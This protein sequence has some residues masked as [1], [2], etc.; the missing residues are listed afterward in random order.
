VTYFL[1][2]FYEYMWNHESSDKL[3]L[4]ITDAVPFDGSRTEMAYIKLGAEQ[5]ALDLADQ[6]PYSCRVRAC[7]VCRVCR[8]CA[9]VVGGLA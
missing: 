3:V 6:V 2:S 5:A 7:R 9:C 1:S 4:A 8:V